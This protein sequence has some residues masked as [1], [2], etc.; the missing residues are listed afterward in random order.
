MG[1]TSWAEDCRQQ[2]RLSSLLKKRRKPRLPRYHS[3]W[4]IRA[5]F[6]HQ[7]SSLSESRLF[8]NGEET[9]FHL[10]PKG[11]SE[12]TQ[13]PVTSPCSALP[14]SN[15]QL[16]EA[17]AGRFFP[18]IV[19]ALFTVAIHHTGA[20]RICQ[21]KFFLT[22]EIFIRCRWSCTRRE[23]FSSCCSVVGRETAPALGRSAFLRLR[24]CWFPQAGEVTKNA[25]ASCK[26]RGKGV[27]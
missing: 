2:K 1:P 5:H 8:G 21:A 9:R 20:N 3:R 27:K 14:R 18:V 25:F 11:L 10:S 22:G 24:V 15:R 12:N 26:S 16:S 13:G 7:L 17:S 19:S 23:R 6:R 4:H